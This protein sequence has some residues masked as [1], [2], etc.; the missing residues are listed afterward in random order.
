VGRRAEEELEGVLARADSILLIRSWPREERRDL[1][2]SWLRVLMVA[3]VLLR[4]TAIVLSTFEL[5][6]RIVYK[7]RPLVSSR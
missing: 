1:I 3:A 2:F 7:L 6:L 5:L 4:S